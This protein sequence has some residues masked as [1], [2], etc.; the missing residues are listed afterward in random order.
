M[1]GEGGSVAGESRRTQ[2]L[3]RL[4]E[5]GSV[6][7]TELVDQF[8]VSEVTIRRDLAML[9]QGGLCRRVRGGALQPQG[10]SYEPP[11]ALRRTFHEAEK[12]AIAEAALLSVTDGDS[13]ALD[14]GSTTLALARRLT[15]RDNLTV[16]TPSLS[17]AGTLAD[18]P[19]VRVLVTGGLLRPSESSLVG[20]LAER[21][22]TDF[23]V[24]R[25]FLGVGG[26][27]PEHGMTEFN[28]E[29]TLVKQA[30]LQTAKETIVLAD[31]SKLDRI[32]FAT[33]A[34]V[35]RADRVVTDAGADPDAVARLEEKGVDVV[36]ASAVPND[37][38][39]ERAAK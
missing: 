23:H 25:L 1:S 21:A 6:S 28:I 33:V 10:R 7:V 9:E 34:P 2:L 22:F 5:Q 32:V 20:H 3:E 16:I 13:I 4:S 17:V 14:V 31:S 38:G 26:I 12:D 35:T 36:V 37:R 27:H 18:H 30:M 29:D 19:R 8:G 39:R 24:D 15:A 11:F